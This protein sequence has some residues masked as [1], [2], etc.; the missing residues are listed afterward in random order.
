LQQVAN[1]VGDA[2]DSQ[3]EFFKR[4][5]RAELMHHVDHVRQ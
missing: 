5:R 3:L 2:G 1:D 4:R